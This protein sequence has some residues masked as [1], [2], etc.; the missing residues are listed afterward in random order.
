MKPF[1]LSVAL[2]FALACGQ[3]CPGNETDFLIK[4]RGA[5]VF[6]ISEAG[7]CQCTGNF[8]GNGSDLTGLGSNAVIVSLQSELAAARDRIAALESRA[9]LGANCYVDAD[10][11]SG[12]FCSP[13]LLRCSL[14]FNQSCAV[15]AQCFDGLECRNTLCLCPIGTAEG[16]D[17]NFRPSCSGGGTTSKAVLTTSMFTSSIFT[18][19]TGSTS[20]GTTAIG[21]TAI[22]T[23]GFSCT[24]SVIWLPT[25]GS[26]F[27]PGAVS[28]CG[29]FA[30]R[31]G[32]HGQS[33]VTP[34]VVYGFGSNWLGKSFRLTVNAPGFMV[35]Y[36]SA[37]GLD[38]PGGVCY[39]G[40]GTSSTWGCEAGTATKTVSTQPM[41]LWLGRG[42]GTC[43]LPAASMF[44]ITNV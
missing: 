40:S 11:Q 17:G 3:T 32:C 9:A 27:T 36:S 19:S 1:L 8:R 42:D 6:R 38:Y 44:T 13:T 39:C 15:S 34:M 25:F 16:M 21:T 41:Y 35:L 2:L 14:S 7:N 30:W 37:C 23:T 31:T 28:T 12:L 43:G 10:C 20:S 26:S 22:G 33:Y 29:N 24:S 18:S 5:V 4:N